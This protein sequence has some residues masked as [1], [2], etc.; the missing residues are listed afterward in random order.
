MGNITK[1]EEARVEPTTRVVRKK[2]VV[3][4]EKRANGM[5]LMRNK[6]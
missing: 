1:S 2:E 6:V 5:G 3:R 4:C